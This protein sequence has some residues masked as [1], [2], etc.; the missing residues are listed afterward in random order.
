MPR[1]QPSFLPGGPR[2]QGFMPPGPRPPTANGI[3][4]PLMPGAPLLQDAK[5]F[6]ATEQEQPLIWCTLWTRCGPTDAELNAGAEPTKQP[7]SPSAG[8]GAAQELPSA[9][10]A[11]GA[12][13][14]APWPLHVH[15]AWCP[16]AGLHHA[17]PICLVYLRGFLDSLHQASFYRICPKN[18][19]SLDAC[20][21]VRANA[22]FNGSEMVAQGPPQG[23]LFGHSPSK[24]YISASGPQRS[25]VAGAVNP[26]D[27]LKLFSMLIIIQ[28]PVM[29]GNGVHEI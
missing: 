3:P 9:A 2:P 6:N 19:S 22:A 5:K 8:D 16:A 7:G 27:T 14:V 24:G 4:P 23:R 12:R 21:S 25:P 28:Y 18:W 20:Q 15:A 13:A 29:S 11:A 17:S 26:S 10:R 1:G